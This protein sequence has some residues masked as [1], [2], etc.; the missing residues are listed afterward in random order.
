MADQSTV[1]VDGAAED[2][3]S[4]SI[5]GL[6]V[7]NRSIDDQIKAD[8]HTSANANATNDAF[9]MAFRKVRPGSAV[10]EGSRGPT[11]L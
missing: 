9:G 8:R 7:V 6:T 11:G 4:V 10:G 5:D 1:D 3:Q 2:P